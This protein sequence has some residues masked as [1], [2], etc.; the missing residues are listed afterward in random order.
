MQNYR[1]ILNIKEVADRI[2]KTGNFKGGAGCQESGSRP[3]R[4]SKQAKRHRDLGRGAGG[5]PGM[6]G[7][8]RILF[9]R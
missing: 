2:E 8:L 6:A 1:K 7:T 4:C 5:L 9:F 3:V